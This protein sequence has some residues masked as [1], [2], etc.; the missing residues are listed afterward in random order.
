LRNPWKEGRNELSDRACFAQCLEELRH[1]G[2]GPEQ[3]AGIL[4]EPM[5]GWN[6]WPIPADFAQAMMDWARQ[7]Q[8]LVCFDE[9]QSGCGRAGKFFA[10]EHCGVVPDL[11]TL[12]KGLTSS[13]PVSAVIGP[14]WLLDQPAPG[15]MSSTHGGNPVCAAAALANLQVIEDEN[16]VE[17]SA[18]AGQIVLAEL[19]QIQRDFQT[20]CFRSTATGCSF[21]SI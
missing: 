7:H 18:Q 20:V 12:G 8:I 13:L 5:P 19:Q 11:I 9:V 15:E 21:R 6:T 16:L 14:S 3:I 2:V 4:V 17:R 10:H 1:Q